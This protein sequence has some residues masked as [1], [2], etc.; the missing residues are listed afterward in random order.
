MGYRNPER[1]DL[2]HHLA[3][4]ATISD[5]ARI[6]WVV[7][8][9]CQACQLDLRIDLELMVRLNGADLVLFGRTCRCR[10]MGCSGRMLFMGTPPG[11]QHGLFWPL[12]AVDMTVAHDA[13]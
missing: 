13:R 2:A 6:G 10:R 1:R 8:A 5:M 9:R 3:T 12:R 11:E 4:P 7:M